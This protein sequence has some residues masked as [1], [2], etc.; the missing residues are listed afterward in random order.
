MPRFCLLLSVL[1]LLVAVCVSFAA[2]RSLCLEGNEECKL[3]ERR[4]WPPPNENM[5]PLQ[6]P[7]KWN[8]EPM[9]WPPKAKRTEEESESELENEVAA[10]FERLW[11]TIRRY[12][13]R[14]YMKPEQE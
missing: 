8:P 7:P 1:C 9:Q 5:A 6:W 10:K 13:E 11:P 2:A 3:R 4:V 12:M 14:H